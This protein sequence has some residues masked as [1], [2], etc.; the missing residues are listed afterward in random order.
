MDQILN[1]LKDVL[2]IGAGLSIVLTI[3]ARVLPNAKIYGFGWS[4]GTFLTTLGHT[5]LGNAT[6]DKVEEFLENSF[7]QFSAGF[8]D[9]L[10][11]DEGVSK[12][13]IEV[14]KKSDTVRK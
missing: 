2:S 4:I 5:K 12:K 7:V 10:N 6:A 1:I 8:V 9:G 13:E 14:P 3:L 11:S